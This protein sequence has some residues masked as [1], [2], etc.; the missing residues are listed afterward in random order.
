MNDIKVAI[1]NIDMFNIS[2]I[3]LL[4]EVIQEYIEKLSIFEIILSLL[5]LGQ[6]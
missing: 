1:G 3:E 6:I 4:E 2:D 5:L